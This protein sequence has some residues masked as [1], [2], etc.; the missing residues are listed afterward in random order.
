MNYPFSTMTIINSYN[1]FSGIGFVWIFKVYIIL[2]LI[3]PF[4]LKLCYSKISNRKYFISLI[5]VYLLYEISMH[6]FFDKIPES[7]KELVSQFFLVII[8]YSCL[9]FY[10]LRL[11][12]IGDKNIRIII[13]TS[14]LIFSGL[15]LQKYFEL[16]RFIP[17]QYYKY[18]P[19]L[20]YLSYA[21]FCI[22]LIYYL[23]MKYI[24]LSNEKFKNLVVWLSTNSLWIYLWH[25]FA[26]YLW[27]FF[28]EELISTESFGSF[29]KFLIK[30]CF[31]LTFGIA[32]T[33]IQIDRV[34]KLIV[35][36]NTTSKKAL[37]LLK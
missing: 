25:I 19:T 4:G 17:T 27:E 2:A 14:L 33:A 1:L 9:F 24:E 20:Y 10:G 37:L 8:P 30:T 26:Y 18:P 28:L 16:D 6:L 5:L 29:G 31:L 22:N 32:M 15:V 34:N 3:T 11:N 13:V 21:F 36:S 12:S 35:K 7:L 23:F